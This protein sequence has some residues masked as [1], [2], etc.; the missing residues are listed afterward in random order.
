M[1][2]N[3]PVSLDAPST[4]LVCSGVPA[5]RLLDVLRHVSGRVALATPAADTR[6]AYAEAVAKAAESL[7]G[8]RLLVHCHMPEAEGAQSLALTPH[9]TW[10]RD[11]DLPMRRTLFTLQAALAPLKASGGAIVGVG[12]SLSIAGVG[13]LVALSTV[14]EGQRSMTKAAARQWLGEGVSVN[15][16]AVASAW[17][18]PSLAEVPG[19]HRTDAAATHTHPP[20]A[21]ALAALLS[22]L[23]GPAGQALAGQTLIADGGEWMTP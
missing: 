19:V 16:L 14:A 5:Q 3:P 7:G 22:A 1:A 2:M 15:W 11:C 13:G 9:E 10:R 21:E 18:A 17:L 4:V 23:A 6:A 12:P 20:T 8:C